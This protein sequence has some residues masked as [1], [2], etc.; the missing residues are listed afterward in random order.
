MRL[1]LLID[2]SY[3]LYQEMPIANGV[4]LSR[5]Y[6]DTLL[7]S[8]TSTYSL[9]NLSTSQLIPL[10]LPISQVTDSPT[11]Q[12][13][14]SI[15]S[16]P[17][18]SGGGCEFLITSHSTDMTLGVFI[19]P[20]GEPSPKLLEWRSHPRSLAYDS[21]N[22]ISLLRDNT[23]EVH[24]LSLED[25]SLSRRQV[26]QL[27]DLLEPRSLSSG[28]NVTRIGMDDGGGEA[29]LKIVIV[30]HFKRTDGVEDGREEE[31][32]KVG[33]STTP[34]RVLLA[35]RNVVQAICQPSF[36]IKAGRLLR[37]ENWEELERLVGSEEMEAGI[38]EERVS[39]AKKN[40]LG[41][42]F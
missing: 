28:T 16:I 30:D 25:L 38:D 37:R 24:D 21:P 7:F 20:S 9:L 6:G 2:S 5:R 36:T 14:P 35:G 10:G 31:E 42:E 41:G 11:A 40:C 32:K 18:T 1:T 22:L 26:I 23:L 17:S 27:P 3:Q 33:A 34:A 12:V 13:K 15:V 39:D 19:T 4:T 29:N 8:D